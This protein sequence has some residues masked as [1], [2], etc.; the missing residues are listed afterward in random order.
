VG[1][2]PDGATITVSVQARDPRIVL[3]LPLYAGKG[4]LW[5]R[6]ATTAINTTVIGT[7]AFAGNLDW[8]KFAAINTMDRTDAAPFT[9]TL[10]DT[11]YLYKAPAAGLNV[12]GG[13]GRARQCEPRLQRSCDQRRGP[14]APTQPAVPLEHE[15]RR[16]L[17]QRRAIPPA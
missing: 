6:M 10:Q 9:V 5:G 2:L 3:Y 17:Q 16:D 8:R 14:G 13:L 12:L 1:K 15:Q 11:G 7:P 4:S